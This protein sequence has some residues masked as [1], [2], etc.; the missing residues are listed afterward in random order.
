VTPAARASRTPGGL[1]RRH[2]LIAVLVAASVA[3]RVLA[4][5]AVKPGPEAYFLA[6]YQLP[7]YFPGWAYLLVLAAGLTGPTVTLLD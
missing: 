5:L 7:V 3:P 4:A 1:W 6:F 2:W